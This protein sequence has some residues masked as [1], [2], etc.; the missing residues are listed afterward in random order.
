MKDVGKYEALSWGISFLLKIIEAPCTALG[1]LDFGHNLLTL[2]CY[3][4]YSKI[5][6]EEGQHKQNVGP[7]IN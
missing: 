1:R 4:Y 5:W 7:F 3:G 2:E 6:V